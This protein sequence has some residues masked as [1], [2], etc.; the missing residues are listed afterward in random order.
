MRASSKLG[1]IS[2]P[3]SSIS[4]RARPSR[5]LALPLGCTSS[6]LRM[7]TGTG[8]HGAVAVVQA[9]IARDAL[10]FTEQFAQSRSDLA[11][12]RRAAFGAAAAG[13]RRGQVRRGEVIAA[14]R[15]NR[16][17]PICGDWQTGHRIGAAGRSAHGCRQ[18]SARTASPIRAAGFHRCR[19]WRASTKPGRHGCC[20]ISSSGA[21][22]A[23]TGR[24]DRRSVGGRTVSTMPFR[25]EQ[26]LQTAGG[27]VDGSE[28]FGI[29]HISN[30]R[31]IAAS[32]R[33][34]DGVWRI[35]SYPC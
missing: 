2:S 12:S 30:Q 6:C 14:I 16:P 23:S 21:T 10:A 25:R 3:K 26:R 31:M 24:R 9:A 34:P 20:A 4:H 5:E 32:S 7:M 35:V 11:I 17:S 28:E 13:G 22:A 19:G 33:I 29:E 15:S 8:G 18:E 27:R 1:M